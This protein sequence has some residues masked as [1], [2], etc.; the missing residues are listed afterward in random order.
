MYHSPFLSQET[1]IIMRGRRHTFKGASK[2]RQD[3]DQDD[4]SIPVGWTD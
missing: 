3:R 2:H 1:D 4:G